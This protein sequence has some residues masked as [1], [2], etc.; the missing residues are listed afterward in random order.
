MANA[1][2]RVY[3][4]IELTRL[5]KT[6]LESRF[7]SIWVE[8]E[9][10]NVKRPASG[11]LYFTIK[12]KQ[13]QIDAVMFRGSQQRLTFEPRDGIMV[14][15]QGD[16]G[17]YEPRG[18]YQIVVRVM[19][20]GGAG[21]LQARFE[22]LKR[23]L[24]A[25]GLFEAGRKRP[26]PLLPRCVGVVTSGTGA[27]FRDILNVIGRRFPHLRIV[28]APVR[29][30]GT[31][32]AEEIAEAIGLLN[33]LGGV[34]AMIVGRGGGSLEDLWA[35]NEECVAR[36]IAASAVPVIS[37]VG[38]E[39]D[40][41]IADFT[42]DLRAPTPSA[43]AEL[44]V[45]RKDAFESAIADMRRRMERALRQVAAAARARLGVL[46]G[47]YVFREPG[48][49]SVRYRQHLT[50]VGRTARQALLDRVRDNRLR[51]DEAA[52][53]MAHTVQMRRQQSG[54]RLERSR[55]QLRALDPRGVLRRGYT[56]TRDADGHLV[57]RAAQVPPGGRL[58]TEFQDGSVASIVAGTPAGGGK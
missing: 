37:A 36:A 11:H 50:Q 29:V 17:V 6:A 47:S 55:L 48:N 51:L 22:A 8:G 9:L 10:S 3:S 30:Q 15:A 25:E 32:A 31:G 58:V 21:A 18:S 2:R 12:D 20:E 5:I 24:Q 35:F 41:T 44:V 33:R 13:A 54:D 1:E 28:L 23:K 56:L 14:Q 38:H 45:G 57:I 39:T 19:E 53:R 46:S 4:I 52:I 7:R 16:I 26:L 49:L 42:A 43:A 27:A 40:F 34:D